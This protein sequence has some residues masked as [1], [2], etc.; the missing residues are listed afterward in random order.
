M[1]GIGEI[2]EP[3]EDWLPAIEILTPAIFCSTGAVY[4]EFRASFMQNINAAQAQE[5]LR[6]S[7]EQLLSQY[8]GF[9]L[10]DLFAPCI[11][12]YLQMSKYRDMFLSG[13]GSSVFFLK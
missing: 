6:L 3:F 1:R 10:N 7:S 8:G 12:L 4:N 2:I 11:K 13:S 5:M 9:T